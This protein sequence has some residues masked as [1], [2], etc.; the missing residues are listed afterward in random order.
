MSKAVKSAKSK[1]RIISQPPP[2]LFSM[3]YLDLIFKLK[4]T[5][6][7]LLKSEEDSKKVEEPENQEEKENTPDDRYYHI[8]DLNTIEDLQ[9]LKNK[10]ELWDKISLSGGNDTLKQILIGKLISKKRCNIEYFA[11]NRPVF[12]DNE[13]FFQEIFDHVCTKHHLIINENP[14]EESARYTLKIILQHKG[15]INTIEIGRSF[16]EEEK[17]RIRKKRRKKRQQERMEQMNNTEQ[18]S[19]K[20]EEIKKENEED[21][22]EESEDEDEEDYEEEQKPDE[23]EETEAMKE[24]KI[25]KFRRHSSILVKLEPKCDKFSMAYIN[26]VDVKR[27]PGDFRMSNL[28]ELLKFF[29]AKGTIIFVNFYKPKRPKIEIEEETLETHENDNEIMDEGKT[30]T[31]QTEEIEEEK[32]PKKEKKEE[33]P[34]RKMRELNELYELTQ[35]YFFDTKQCK[36]IYNKHYQAFTT[37]NPIN[38][39][40]ITK[41]NVFDYFIKGIAPATKDEVTGMKTGLFIDQL[42]K[43]TIIYAS[44]KA[45][46]TQ[47]F[48]SQPHPKINHNNM[49]LIKEYKDILSDNKNDYYSILLSSII[50]H[51]TVNSP[52]CQSTEVIYPGFL[53]SLEVVKKRLECEKNHFIPDDNIYKV[54]LDEK[55]IEKNLEIF[56]SGGKENGFVLDCTNKQKSK[57]KDYVSLYDYHLQ[58]FFTSDLIRKELLNKGFINSKGFIM[59]DPVYRN[60]MRELNNKKKK[61]ISEEEMKNKVMNS[62]NKINVPSNIKDKE[63]DAKRL[64]KQKNLPTDLKLPINKELIYIQQNIKKKI[65]KKRKANKTSSLGG[66]SSDESDGNN[67]GAE[68]SNV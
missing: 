32:K 13:E 31:V 53:I 49:S 66:G 24:K 40:N 62:I 37:D 65:K 14:L 21:D 33:G 26:F 42:N 25:P 48:D 43:L 8:E 47:E 35:I 64:A 11:Y 2:V 17:E 56:A 23:Y 30:K 15:E 4:L 38:W 34:P 19:E 9:F 5:N 55:V 18:A 68:E 20:E 7:D 27:V 54:K 36:K 57:M 29:K 61:K 1:S 22:E 67:S 58:S 3:G 52:N 6:K 63:I 45:A 51:C 41:A 39:K 44:K 50:I 28:L 60:V 59:Y 10:K 46:Y 16:E 12:K